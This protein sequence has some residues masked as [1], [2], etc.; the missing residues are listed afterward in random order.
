MQVDYQTE[1]RWQNA[2]ASIDLGKV[3]RLKE[4]EP[5]ESET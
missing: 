4:H 1:I 3:K 2:F 5:R